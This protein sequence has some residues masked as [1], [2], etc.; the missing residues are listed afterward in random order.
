MHGHRSAIER[1]WEDSGPNPSP[2]YS[3]PAA[4]NAPPVPQAPPASIPPP[5]QHRPGPAAA[6]FAPPHAPPAGPPPRTGA[7]AAALLC[8]VLTLAF[9][10]LGVLAGLPVLAVLSNI[11]GLVF[12]ALAVAN[13]HDPEAVERNIAR[14]WACT[15]G[16]LLLIALVLL[17][18]AAL[19]TA[20]TP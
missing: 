6:P 15:L 17:A 16:Y 1:F 10:A 8:A 4:H 11:P 9:P 12:G 2:V 13:R 5:P 18:I 14:T 7:A 20:L 3:A 19:I